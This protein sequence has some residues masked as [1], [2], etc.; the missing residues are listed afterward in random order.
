MKAAE[1]R[2][3]SSAELLDPRDGG[4][5]K[6]H[7][8]TQ[9]TGLP[10][11]RVNASDKSSERKEEK[12]R[13]PGRIG[14][15]HLRYVGVEQEIHGRKKGSPMEDLR[16]YKSQATVSVMGVGPAA[17]DA[18]DPGDYGEHFPVN[19]KRLLGDARVAD[20]D[21]GQG[22]NQQVRQKREKTRRLAAFCDVVII[23]GGGRELGHGNAF[24]F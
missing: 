11:Q 17:D 12:D 16:P 18:Q 20:A 21:K 13:K 3:R 6:P 15:Q 10:G 2:T 7:H 4:N 24:P 8:H 1:A 23:F 14:A 5:R 9:Q 22:Q 19:D